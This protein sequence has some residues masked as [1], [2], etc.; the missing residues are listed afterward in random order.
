MQGAGVMCVHSGYT[1]SFF[2]SFLFTNLSL[3]V[4]GTNVLAS[5]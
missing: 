5:N 2:F 3:M 1:Y 4:Q